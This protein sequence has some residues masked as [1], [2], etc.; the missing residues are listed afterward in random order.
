MVLGESDTE[1]PRI[2]TECPGT[3]YW[4]LSQVP[5]V[6]REPLTGRRRRREEEEEVRFGHKSRK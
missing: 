4:I 2:Q 3:A 5:R 1:G 6:D